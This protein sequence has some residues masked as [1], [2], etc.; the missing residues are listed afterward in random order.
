VLEA[1]VSTLTEPRRALLDIP[2]MWL[3]AT[4]PSGVVGVS[5]STSPASGEFR[6]A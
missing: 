1:G 5:G 4:P 6:G 2:P 3:A